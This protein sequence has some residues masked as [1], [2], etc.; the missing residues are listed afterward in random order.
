MTRT[1]ALARFD[2]WVRP[3]ITSINPYFASLLYTNGRKLFISMLSRELPLFPFNPDQKLKLWDLEFN[4]N[5]FNAAGIFKK[6]EAYMTCAMQGAGAWLAG[7]TTSIERH[8]NEKK[9]IIHPFIPYPN[10]NAASNWMGL[11]NEGH[12]IVAKRISKLVKF[13]GCQIGASISSDPGLN[14]DDTMYGLMEGFY[15]NEKAGVDFIELNESCPNVEHDSCSSDSLD[16]NLLKRLEYISDNFLKDRKRNLPVIVK[17]SVDT[18]LSLLPSLLVTLISMGY[19]GINLGNTSTEYDKCRELIAEKDRISFD[20]FI[21]TFGGGVSG[22]PLKKKSLILAAKAVEHVNAISPA[23][24]FHVIRT[25]GIETSQDL[26]DSASA[27]IQLNQ[28]FTGYFEGFSRYGH[29]VYRKI[30]S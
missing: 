17:F 12:E 21:N 2:L 26:E 4:S 6:G 27:G 29:N 28:W 22:N 13:R 25:G 10:S 30:L 16:E 9:G 8:G 18:D 15:L 19:D 11:P 5:I 23:K 24:E 7:T 3:L 1:E 14:F 20:Y